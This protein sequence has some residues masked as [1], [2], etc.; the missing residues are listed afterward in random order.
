MKHVMIWLV[1]LY[2]KFISPALPPACR[3]TPTCS[4]YAIEAFSKR[5][6]FVGSFLT[7]WRI[8]RC[9]PFCKAGYDPVPDRGLIP[10]ILRKKKSSDEEETRQSASCHQDR[11]AQENTHQIA[12]EDANNTKD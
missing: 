9:N 12:E 1:R 3:F 8:L 11:D 6:F 7:L 5:G 2:K 10:T 4:E